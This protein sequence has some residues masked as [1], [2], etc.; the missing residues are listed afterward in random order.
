ME[1]SGCKDEVVQQDTEGTVF[2]CTAT[3]A[4]GTAAHSVS[5]KRDTRGPVIG[6]T[7]HPAIY[8]VDQRIVIGCRAADGL[9]G[10]ASHTC[11]DM[12]ADAY[13][14]VGTT[15]LTATATD[16]AGNTTSAATEFAVQVTEVGVCVLTG[17]WVTNAGIAH[18]MCVKLT[19]AAAAAARGNKAA[20]AGLHRAF[21]QEVDAQVGKAISAE[22]ARVLVRV[23]GEL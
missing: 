22:H 14:M 21:V 10:V 3:S 15:R 11:Q 8:S 13:E 5:V 17:R 19:N 2:S 23:V 9:S 12:D 18:S 4:G 16:R 6:Y 7:A 1:L 20:Q